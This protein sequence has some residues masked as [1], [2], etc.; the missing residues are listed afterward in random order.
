MDELRALGRMYVLLR[1]FSLDV[2]MRMLKWLTERSLADEQAV[3]AGESKGSS[4]E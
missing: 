4:D 1:P 3:P 2:R